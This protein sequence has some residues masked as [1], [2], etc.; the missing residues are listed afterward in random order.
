MGGSSLTRSRRGRDREQRCPSQRNGV[1]RC[2]VW[3]DDRAEQRH[4]QPCARC[5]SRWSRLRHRR[6][7]PPARAARPYGGSGERSAHSLLRTSLA[8]AGKS[9]G[10]L[11]ERDRHAR[12]LRSRRE[13]GGGGC[14]AAR[15][16]G[17]ALRAEGR[18]ERRHNAAGSI[19]VEARLSRVAAGLPARDDG[20]GSHRRRITRRIR[21]SQRRSQRCG[22]SWPRTGST[23]VEGTYSHRPTARRNCSQ[24]AVRGDPEGPDAITAVRHLRSDI[25]S[26]F[27]GTDGTVL[28]GGDSAETAD[29][30]DSVSKPA[31]YV[32][33]SCLG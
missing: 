30:L 5:D 21:R 16:G 8:R 15:A 27:A 10:S 33:C 28:V 32:S 1:R 19:P 7:D 25:T 31:P 9:R 20:S 18:L 14:P 3:D 22:R 23:W 29:Y 24:I 26:V 11:L 13:P 4:A 6:A 12:P 17:A 2:D